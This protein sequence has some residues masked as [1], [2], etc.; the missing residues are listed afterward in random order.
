GGEDYFRLRHPGK[1]GD[2]GASGVENRLGRFSRG[3]PADL[4]L[5]SGVAG[6]GVDHGEALPRTCGAVQVQPGRRRPG[7]PPGF[8]QACAHLTDS[9]NP[10]SPAASV[11]HRVRRSPA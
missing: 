1:R 2:G 5:V 7:G 4:G 11:H 8:G 10:K 9:D 6:G 3:V